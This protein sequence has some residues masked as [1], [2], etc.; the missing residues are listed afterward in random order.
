MGL[1]NR[2]VPEAELDAFVDAYVADIAANAPLTIRAARYAILQV[3][4]DETK[5]DLDGVNARSTPAS[6][7]RTTW[8]AET[9]SWK[10]ASRSSRGTDAGRVT[11]V[12]GNLSRVAVRNC[13]RRSRCGETCRPLLGVPEA[14]GFCVA[15]TCVFY[16][17]HDLP[18]TASD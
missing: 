18:R 7:A 16:V 2:V 1:V 12:P 6:K 15:A 11:A 9:P 17:A 10:S 13:T 3:L 5:R 4:T 14:D 8:K